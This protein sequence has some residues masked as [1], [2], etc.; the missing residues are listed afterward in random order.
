MAGRRHQ[1]ALALP[2]LVL[3]AVALALAPAVVRGGGPEQVVV[4]GDAGDAGRAGGHGGGVCLPGTSAAEADGA[5]LPLQDSTEPWPC[6]VPRV[7]LASLSLPLRGLT[8]PL[9]IELPSPTEEAGG[10]RH[11]VAFADLTTPEALRE[12]ARGEQFKVSDG[13]DSV[14]RPSRPINQC[15]D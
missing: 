7:P 11:N 9:V 8:T 2:V 5:P 14:G 10:R 13:W 3:L 1:R 4:A 6:T 12:R 15:D